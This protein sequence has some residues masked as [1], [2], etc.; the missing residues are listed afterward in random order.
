MRPR[1]VMHLDSNSKAWTATVILQLVADGKLH[2]RDTVQRWLPGL[3]PNGGRITIRELLNHTSGLASARDFDPHLQ[4]AISRVTDPALRARLVLALRRERSDPAARTPAMLLVRLVAAQPLLF[5]PGTGWHYTNEGYD[6]L[7]MIAARAGGEP[8]GALYQRRIIEPLRLAGA[9]YRPQ[10]VIKAAHPQEYS[11]GSHGSATDATGWYRGGN[12]AGAGIV[13][14]AADEGRFLTA[15]MQGRL[16][17]PAELRAMLTPTAV[18]EN[19]GFGLVR[20]PSGC[21]GMAFQHGGAGYSTTSSV[22]VSRDGSRVAVV[23][24]DGNTLGSRLSLDPGGGNSVV[25]ASLRLFCSAW[26][27]NE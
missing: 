27:H 20:T 24:A 13:A 1:L 2:L 25:I 19:Y 18:S 4:A 22:F 16:I 17:P 26:G 9:A 8:L 6:I 21:A 7:G 12:G 10:G 14:D 5:P 15:L 23:L 3:L 11:I